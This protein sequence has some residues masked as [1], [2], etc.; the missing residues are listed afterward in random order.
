MATS[1]GDTAWIEWMA[2]L[3]GV[4]SRR[5]DTATLPMNKFHCL[6][7]ELPL[8]LIPKGALP[9]K[10]GKDSSSAPLFLNPNCS[11][12]PAGEVPMELHARRDLLENFCLDCTVAWL[13][14]PSTNSIHPFWL[15][16]R[17]EEV[18]SEFKAT[19]RT[20]RSLSDEDELLLRTAGILTTADQGEQRSGKWSEEVSLAAHLFCEKNYAPLRNLIH[21]FNLA[22]LRRYYRHLIRRGK[23]RLGDEQSSRR[24]V[25]HN[26]PVARYFHHQISN[27]VG[28][29]VGEPVK[30]SY[31]YVASYLGGAE[32]KKHIDRRQCEFTVTLCLDFSPEPENGTSWPICLETVDGRVTVYQA[33]GDGLMYG[34]TRVPHY[35]NLLRDGYTSTSIFFHYVPADF[36]GS[37]D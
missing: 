9:L 1:L 34:G 20:T 36:S 33:L 18:V 26:E 32:L 7:E 3:M 17:L 2:K 37:L 4:A 13:R 23:I 16:P 31:V 12:L 27:V 8:H 11:V 28:A 21:P 24:Y 15:G 6:L 35:R 19:A 22:A 30:P 10:C 25:A 14:D 5:R 29:V